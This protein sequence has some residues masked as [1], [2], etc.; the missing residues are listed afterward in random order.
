MEFC[1]EIDLEMR[2][3]LGKWSTKKNLFHAYVSI[4]VYNS[5]YIQEG[6]CHTPNNPNSETGVGNV[7][8]EDSRNKKVLI[9][10]QHIFDCHFQNPFQKWNPSQPLY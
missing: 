7:L 5:Y 10:L 3:N 1:C 8:I 6:I 9:S 2:E 4:R